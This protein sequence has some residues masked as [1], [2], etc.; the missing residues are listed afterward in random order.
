MKNYYQILN[1][2]QTATKEEIRKNYRKLALEFHPDKNKNPNAK[3]KFIEINIAYETLINE[4][5]RAEYDLSLLRTKNNSSTNN[6]Q[7]DYYEKREK[8]FRE[9]AEKYASQNFENFRNTIEKAKKVVNKIQVGCGCI[10]GLL[11]ILTVF[12]ILTSQWNSDLKPLISWTII[13]F[14]IYY[15]YKALKD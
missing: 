14:G 13:I 9:Q 8:E 15:I 6:R 1:I 2:N 11:I 7:S 3:E 10:I 5:L 4:Q 12:G